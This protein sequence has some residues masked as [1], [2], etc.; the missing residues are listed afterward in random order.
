[1]VG[2]V[3]TPKANEPVA[4]CPSTAE[5]V[6]Q[7]TVYTP[8]PNGLSG[9]VSCRG[10][11]GT[12]ALGPELTTLPLVSSTR[13]VDSFGSGSSPNV[14]VTAVGGV[15]RFAPALGSDDCGRE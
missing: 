13:I 6:R 9:T 2:R 12:T 1:M 8:G 5:T 3:P 14:M 11:S 15:A 10:S 7:A 4:R